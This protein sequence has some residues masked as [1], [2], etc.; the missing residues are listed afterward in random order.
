MGSPQLHSANGI[1]REAGVMVAILKEAGVTDYEPRVVSQMLEF[2]YRY[3]SDILEDAK[4][5]SEHAE[6]KNIDGEDVE[7]AIQ[8]RVETSFTRPP[9]REFLVDLAKE[10][11]SVPL[12][13]IKQQ[14]GLKLPPDRYCLLQPNYRLNSR[15][16]TVPQTRVSTPG[17]SASASSQNPTSSGSSNIPKTTSSSV[18]ATVGG[19]FR[20][21]TED[22]TGGRKRKRDP[23]L[24]EDYDT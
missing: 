19:M 17:V 9:P 10:K 18:S 23:T 13:D 22:S 21:S 14:Y 16:S 1:P 4:V 24:D 15:P 6:K 20:L 7:L 2:A 8:S 12:P 5:Y 3:V 11:N